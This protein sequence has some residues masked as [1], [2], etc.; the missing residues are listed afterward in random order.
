MTTAKCCQRLLIAEVGLKLKAGN[1]IKKTFETCQV[2]TQVLFVRVIL[3]T[4]K[5]EEN[6]KKI[7]NNLK[8]ITSKYNRGLIFSTRNSMSSSMRSSPTIVTLFRLL[9]AFSIK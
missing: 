5:N 3:Q 4:L 2:L 1:E 8:N 9:L 6:E 7:K